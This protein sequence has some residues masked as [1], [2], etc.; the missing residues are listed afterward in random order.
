MKK[1]SFI[2]KVQVPPDDYMI[3]GS[4]EVSAWRGAD[5]IDEHISELFPELQDIGLTDLMEGSMEYAGE[6]SRE[7]MV[8]K[9]KEL[10]FSAIAI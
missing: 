3:E 9:L 7:E 4:L 1:K 5:M 10:G 8:V 2:L 6:L